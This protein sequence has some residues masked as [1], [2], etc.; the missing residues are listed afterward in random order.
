[1]PRIPESAK[2]HQKTLAGSSEPERIEPSAAPIR[3]F[4]TATFFGYKGM[5]DG[6][7]VNNTATVHLGP[8]RDALPIALEPGE[9]V[10]WS[11]PEGIQETLNDLWIKGEAGDGVHVMYYE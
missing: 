6:L 7:G 2:V 1:M 10:N 3:Y 11:P 8:T 4:R 5:S 9:E